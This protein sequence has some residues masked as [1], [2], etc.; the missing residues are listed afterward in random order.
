MQASNFHKTVRAAKRHGHLRL[1]SG[2]EEGCHKPVHVLSRS[3]LWRALQEIC[4]VFDG[5][6]EALAESRRSQPLSGLADRRCEVVGIEDD[7][8]VGL[9]ATG[10]GRASES[11]DECRPGRAAGVPEVEI[12]EQRDVAQGFSTTLMIA[13]A[14][15]SGAVTIGQ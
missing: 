12:P 3:N 7:C 15:S 14:T 8:S 11:V 1:G 5:P 4:Y 2:V 13:R 6:H 10:D 9:E